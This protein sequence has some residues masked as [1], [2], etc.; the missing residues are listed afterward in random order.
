MK[1]KKIGMILLVFLLLIF[2]VSTVIFIHR[3]TELKKEKREK[4]KVL[5][6]RKSFSKEI[7]TTA[8]KKIYKKEKDQYIE[9]G[10]I[11]KDIFLPL[12]ISDVKTSSDI[13]FKI[14]GLDYYIDYLDIERTSHRKNDSLENVVSTKKITTEQTNLYK[15]GTLVFTF[16][17]SFTFDVLLEQDSKYYVSFL[18]DIYYI[19]DQFT[20]EEV[21]IP[22]LDK[23]SVLSFE[24]DISLE[25]LDEVLSF[26]KEQGYLTITIQDFS[27]FIHG[28][29]KLKEKSVLLLGD[30]NLKN[31]YLQTF[32]KYSYYLETDT[33]TYLFQEGDQQISVS[34]IVYYRYVISNTTSISRVNDMLNGVKKIVDNPTQVAVLNYHFF[35]D[36]S[37]ES[38]NESI[39]LSTE[40]FKEQ[41]DY[42]KNNG[43]KTL[44]MQEFY[45]WKVGNLEIPKKSVLLTIDD[46]AMGTD[47]HLPAILEEYQMHASLFLIT[48]WWDVS[49]YQKSSYLEIY[50]HGDELHHN[51]YCVGSSCGYKPLM[52]SKDEII[53]D[54][55][56]SLSKIP[57]NSKLAFCYPFY[58]TNKNLENALKEVGISLA[59]VG[60]NKKASKNVSNYY[61]P[62]Y[63]VY[64]NTSL[65]QFI[66]MVS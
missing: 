49:K 18:D 4:E 60:G 57:N 8:K 5:E 29:G 31:T 50:S 36:S 22:A 25:K 51:N 33:D 32:S 16:S 44:T 47:T 7:V 1:K 27:Y 11:E 39:C 15:D 41:L 9:V 2:V 63:V 55:N 13:Y 19:Q 14:Q 65:N 12:E 61:I 17:D 6:I 46:G 66:Q 43:Y 58:R 59:F 38:C 45:D 3:Q 62:R 37:S 24:S 30:E 56:L 28:E 34:D 42:L 64:K 48:G 23:L 53:Q 20:L 40:S 10:F 52:L 21:S 54:L 35:Y 26:L